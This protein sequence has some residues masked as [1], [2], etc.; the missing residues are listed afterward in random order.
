MLKKPFLIFFIIILATQTIY[1]QKSFQKTGK[2]SYYADKFHQKK[3]A[4]GEIYDKEK[5][6]AAHRTLPFGTI[7]K[8]TN[9]QN[10]KTTTVRIN[11][12]G[13]AI[14]SRIIDVSKA[15]ALEL[16]MIKAGVVNVSIEI[17]PQESFHKRRQAPELVKTKPLQDLPRPVAPQLRLKKKT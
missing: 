17:I 13:P 11:D 12:R 10:K 5:F 2:A 9:L 6:T 16:D 3:T 1:S 15:A 8:I 4:N 7:V 14:Q